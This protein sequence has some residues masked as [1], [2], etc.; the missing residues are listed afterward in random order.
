MATIDNP[1]PLLTIDQ[2]ADRLCTTIRHV[3]RLIAERR[4][5]YIK[6]GGRVRFDPED[7]EGWLRASRRPLSADPGRRSS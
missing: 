1:P 5:P 4:V 7:I 6:V 3:R 2:L